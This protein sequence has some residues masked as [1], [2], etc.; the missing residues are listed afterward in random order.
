V[1]TPNALAGVTALRS[2][3]GGPALGAPAVNAPPLTHAGPTHEVE[4]PSTTA[5]PPAPLEARLDI[6]CRNAD[7]MS[8]MG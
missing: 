8:L 5:L 4:L 1:A 7:M 3:S 2:H 6:V